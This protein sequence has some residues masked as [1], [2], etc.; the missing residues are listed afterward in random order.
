MPP[1]THVPVQSP[2]TLTLDWAM[3]L[4]L[5]NG[6]LAN[7]MQAETFK[8]LHIRDQPL[9]TLPLAISLPCWLDYWVM[10]GYMERDPKGW[11]TISDLLASGKLSA[12]C[13][14]MSKL[15][16]HVGP[17]NHPANPSQ[18]TE[19]WETTN[20]CYKWQNFGVVCYIKI[21]NK[22]PL[23]E[24]GVTTTWVSTCKLVHTHRKSILYWAL[25]KR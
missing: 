21:N 9:G 25:N 24:V 10:R 1:D 23:Y 19:S 13:I 4:A 6:T 3:G 17:K 15:L 7:M 12:E 14:H 11:A 16:H 2:P 18:R 8:C 5:D 22:I 20:C